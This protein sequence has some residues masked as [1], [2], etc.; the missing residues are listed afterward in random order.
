MGTSDGKLWAYFIVDRL[1]LPYKKSEIIN[2]ACEASAD[3]VW[4]RFISS[5]PLFK[6]VAEKNRM[7]GPSD[8]YGYL[9]E[10]S[11]AGMRS[12]YPSRS[13]GR[14][15]IGPRILSMKMLY[16]QGILPENPPEQK[17][18]TEPCNI[19]KIKTP[20]DLVGKEIVHTSPKSTSFGK[21]V[22]IKVQNDIITVDFADIGKKQLYYPECIQ[23]SYIRI[24]GT[25]SE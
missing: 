22:V 12:T 2:F 13:H 4:E 16:E 18:K 21:G 24:I 15:I 5:K 11:Y 9:R 23:K 6:K 14:S 17:P 19:E 20:V 25:E 7:Y 8:V 10:A 1:G 3:A